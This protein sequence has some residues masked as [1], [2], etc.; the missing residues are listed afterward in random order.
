ML[1]HKQDYIQYKHIKLKLQYIF[2]NLRFLSRIQITTQNVF[3][4]HWQFSEITKK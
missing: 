1:S 2:K 3:N 4:L